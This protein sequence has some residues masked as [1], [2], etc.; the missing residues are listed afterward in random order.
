MAREV[1]R[2]DLDARG[3]ELVDGRSEV[4][5][6]GPDGMEEHDGA[7]HA[8]AQVAQPVGPAS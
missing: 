1:E 8:C 4:L 7:P 6:L 5:E 3:V 2:D